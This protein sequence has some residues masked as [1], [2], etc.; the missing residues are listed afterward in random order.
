MIMELTG[1]SKE[2]KLAT[3]TLVEHLVLADQ[4]VSQ[5][6]RKYIDKLATAFGD[7]EYRALLDEA[8]THLGS[9][10][11]VK[12]LLSGIS[13]QEARN[14]IYGIVMECAFEHGLN[15]EESELLAWLAQEWKIEQ[16]PAS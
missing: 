10:E 2:E 15:A 7:D 3:V 9:E 11:A 12:A 1:L 6:E 4:N 14:L 8:D 13:G 16:G 5:A